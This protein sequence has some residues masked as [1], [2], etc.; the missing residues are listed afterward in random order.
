MLKKTLILATF[1]VLIFGLSPINTKALTVIDCQNGSYNTPNGSYINTYS[2]QNGISEEEARQEYEKQCKP[3][4]LVDFQPLVVRL[5]YFVWI[6][7]G[8][9]FIFGFMYIGYIYMTSAGDVQKQGDLRQKAVYL[10]GA[11]ILLFASQPIATI[12]MRTVVTSNNQCF[13]G[14]SDTPGFTFFFSEVCDSDVALKDPVADGIGGVCD[15]TAQPNDPAGCFGAIQLNFNGN[16]LNV[17]AE[18]CEPGLVIVN[19]PNPDAFCADA[20]ASNPAFNLFAFLSSNPSCGQ[21]NRKIVVNG[22]Q[23]FCINSQWSDGIGGP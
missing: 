1:L 18:T 17:P 20:T 4:N 10:V 12:L 14:I 6:G 19:Q 2:I 3:P 13:Q 22:V 21:E 11:I 16:A 7:S 9:V 23:I 15:V 8:V 5:I